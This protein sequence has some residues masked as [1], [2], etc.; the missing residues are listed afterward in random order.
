MS[1]RMTSPAVSVVMAAY[2]TE[3]FV[4]QAIESVLGQTWGDLELHLVDDGSTDGTA[5]VAQRYLADPRVRYHYQ[6]NAG[7]CAAKNRGVAESRGEFVAFLDADDAWRPYKLARQMP[8]FANPGVGVVYCDDQLMD[9]E[10]RR[11]PSGVR[12]MHSGRITNELLVHN[13]VSFSTSVVRR[14][15]LE[16]FGAFDRSLDMGIDYDLWLRLSP[17]CEFDYVD[18]YLVDYRIWSGQM[19]KKVRE[20][21]AAGIHIMRCFLERNPDAASPR[22]VRRAW[23]HT[24]VGR[25]NSLLW[26][27]R[28]LT[29]AVRDLWRA[30]RWDPTYWRVYWWAARM[31][32]KHSP[33]RKGEGRPK[34]PQPPAAPHDAEREPGP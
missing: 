7:Q 18:E 23:A 11:L 25:G 29:G 34:P 21:Y 5:A 27:E 22:A 13:F 8:L 16:R 33:P 30:W 20:R 19:S 17:H 10:G 26:T 9:E 3:R 6:P 12:T 14:E 2:N 32:V 15:L 4:A 31:V 28:D 24:Y 1:V